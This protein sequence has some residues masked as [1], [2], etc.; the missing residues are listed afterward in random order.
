[1]SLLFEDQFISNIHVPITVLSFIFEMAPR[2]SKVEMLLYADV[3]F[4]SG[5][6]CHTQASGNLLFGTDFLLM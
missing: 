4:V 2:H 5:V 6:R 3:F 1:M